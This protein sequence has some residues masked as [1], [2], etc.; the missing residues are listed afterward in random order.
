MCYLIAKMEF[1]GSNPIQPIFFSV[2]EA[3]SLKHI[4]FNRIILFWIISL[5]FYLFF[6]FLYFIHFA[7]FFSFHFGRYKSAKLSRPLQCLNRWIRPRSRSFLGKGQIAPVLCRRQCRF[8]S[9]A[10]KYQGCDACNFPTQVC[11]R[12]HAFAAQ[13]SDVSNSKVKVS[14]GNESIGPCYEL[15]NL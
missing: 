12:L 7:I 5:F 2:E 11:Y 3:N 6:F 10:V 8:A 15:Y 1:S 4:F 14:H 9:I 13:I